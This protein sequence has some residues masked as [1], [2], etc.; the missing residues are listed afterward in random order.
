MILSHPRLPFRHSGTASILSRQPSERLAGE[1]SPS[2]SRPEGSLTLDGVGR[3]A[4]LLPAMETVSQLKTGRPR[5]SSNKRRRGRSP[6]ESHAQRACPA[7]PSRER[8]RSARREGPPM[9]RRRPPK[10]R[11][12]GSERSAPAQVT[13]QSANA[14]KPPS[15]RAKR[16]SSLSSTSKSEALK[17][18]SPRRRAGNAP[19][20]T[21]SAPTSSKNGGG[22][23]N[24]TGDQGF[25]GPCLTAWLR[26]LGDANASDAPG[27]HARPQDVPAT[28]GH[29]KRTGPVRT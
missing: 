17:P 2:P 27:G 6:G 26:R 3:A 19:R 29:V 12:T 25:A 14:P 8:A 23:R 28:P 18:L 24:R 1:L 15:H 20:V 9:N 11:S 21:Q 22:A 7:T 13:E 5:R 4:G 16:P 10:R